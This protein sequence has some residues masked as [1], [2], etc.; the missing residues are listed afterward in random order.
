MLY[1][2]FVHLARALQRLFRQLFVKTGKP[3]YGE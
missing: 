1:V 2:T 3:E